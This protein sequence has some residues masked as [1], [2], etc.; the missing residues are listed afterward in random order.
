MLKQFSLQTLQYAINQALSLDT[1]TLEKIKKL[2]GKI[3]ELIISPLN[4]HFYISFEQSK[5]LLLADTILKPDTIIHSSPIGLIRLS[6]LPSSKMRSLFN[7]S[8]QI[9]GDIQLGQQLK[10]IF[11]HIDI[12]WEGHLAHFTG[13]V[14]A[15]HIGKIVK[16]GR[17]L[18]KRYKDSFKR[19]SKE[20]LMHELQMT[21]TSSELENYYQGVDDL[22]LRTERLIAH[23]HYLMAENEKA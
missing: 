16:K 10:E 20:Y 9:S 12:D 3:I 14:A 5:V 15:Y 6:F 11:D 8:I 1:N 17:S 2:E 19:N 4:V 18:Q 7:D 21:P 13:D 22:R 23:V